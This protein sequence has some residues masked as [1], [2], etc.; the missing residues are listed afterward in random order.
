MEGGLNL[1][2][3]WSQNF[4]GLFMLRTSDGKIECWGGRMPYYDFTGNHGITYTKGETV[5]LSMTYRPR[6]L[7]AADPGQILYEVTQNSTTYSSGWLNFDQGT[8]S[9]GPTYGLWGILNN[10]RVGG[11][12]TPQV[13]TSDPTNYGLAEFD[14][15][16][17]I[18]EPATLTLLALGG[19]AVLR[20][21]K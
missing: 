19:A 17:F 2:P 7:S 16:V 13:N 12:V 3:W 4:D 5:R 14:N 15:I 10:A 20:R 9:E 6:G 21:R 1:S 11:W 8:L 18:P